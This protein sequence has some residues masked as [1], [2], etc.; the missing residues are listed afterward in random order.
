M[1]TRTEIDALKRNWA[2]DPCYEIE[3]C[4]GFEEHREELLVFKAAMGARWEVQ[5]VERERERREEQAAGTWQ[6][7]KRLEAIE[8]LCW[9]TD[10]SKDA[11]AAVVSHIID[12]AKEELRAE[13][14]AKG[15]TP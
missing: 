12:A 13:F 1:K 4:E 9:D 10:I 8:G 6:S 11:A 5:R 14:V 15:G 7:P 2:A 3:D